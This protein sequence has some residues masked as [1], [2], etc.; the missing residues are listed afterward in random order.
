MPCFMQHNILLSRAFYYLW[1]S[2]CK[3]HYLNILINLFHQIYHLKNR[4]Y[5]FESHYLPKIAI[6]SHFSYYLWIH[7]YIHL[8]LHNEECLIHE[9]FHEKNILHIFSFSNKIFLYRVFRYLR[10]IPHKLLSYLAQIISPYH[11]FSHF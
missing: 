2:L 9:I 11:V 5:I 3:H 8:H 10:I 1:N 7:L 6:P 4:L